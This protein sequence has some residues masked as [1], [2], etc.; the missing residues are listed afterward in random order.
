[1]V[2]AVAVAG[3]RKEESLKGIGRAQCRWAK[4][5]KKCASSRG[6]S[7]VGS[8]SVCMSETPGCEARS[9]KGGGGN[10]ALNNDE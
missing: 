10:A 7:R 8:T 1:M 5:G 2:S 6:G 4:E 3:E 9:L